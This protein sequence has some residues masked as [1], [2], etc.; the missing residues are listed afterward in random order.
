MSEVPAIT[1][2][3]VFLS[4][5]NCYFKTSNKCILVD[6]VTSVLEKPGRKAN[7]GKGWGSKTDNFFASSGWGWNWWVP[8]IWAQRSSLFCS[9][10]TSVHTS[11]SLQMAR[12][13]KREH[14]CLNLC[15]RKESW[16]PP[17]RH[18]RTSC[19]WGVFD[20]L[21]YLV[22]FSILANFVEPDTVHSC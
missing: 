9:E 11:S 3:N 22:E 1:I 12:R 19:N 16:L 14:S 7:T 2:W 20:N 18:L 17:W 15:K 10:P 5:K 6:M 13:L 4:H 8:K 21:K